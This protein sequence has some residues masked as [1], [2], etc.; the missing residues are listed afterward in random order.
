MTATAAPVH[1]DSQRVATRGGRR[2]TKGGA[3]RSRS[4]LSVTLVLWVVCAAIV[5]VSV[6]RIVFFAAPRPAAAP[7]SPAATP[8]EAVATLEA[9]VSANPTDVVA[10]QALGVAYVRKAAQVG[11]P[12]YYGLAQTAFDHADAVEPGLDETLVGRG[13]LAL[14]RHQFAD[15]LAFGT[16]A[17]A[18]NPDDPD[19]LAVI[20][21][22]LVE[23]G[24]YEEAGATLQEL[25]DRRPGLPAY[26]RLSYLRE[27][28]GDTAGAFRAMRQADVAGTGLVYDRATIATFLGDLEFSRGHVAAAGAEYHRALRLQPDLVLA[29]LGLAKVAAARGDRPAAIHRLRTLTNRIPLPAALSVLGDLEEQAGLTVGAAR[30]FGTVRTIAELQRASGQVTDLEMAIFEADH[31]VDSAGADSAVEVARRAY[32]VRPENVFVDDALAWSLYRAGDVDA[33]LPLVDQALRLDTQDALL[34]YHAAVIADAA[35]QSTRA[36]TE[37]AKV[38]DRNPWFSFRYH[39]A[40]QTLAVRLGLPLARSGR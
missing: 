7:A 36:R 16:R 19:A 34:H 15:A 25:L 13:L 24:R 2:V 12:A 8:A 3:G 10:L 5:G 38:L 9:R 32:A 6:G 33:A 40:A 29:D 14:S 18:D 35:G 17:H 30:S 23:L 22:S 27:L 31:A 39:D 20:V 21:D 26:S 4:T 11:D 1:A 28:Q 37:L